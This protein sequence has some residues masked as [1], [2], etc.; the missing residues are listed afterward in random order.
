MQ[1]TS[2]QMTRA[3]S[4]K[5]ICLARFVMMRFYD[6]NTQGLFLMPTCDFL[7]FHHHLSVKNGLSSVSFVQSDEGNN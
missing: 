3:Q 4:E 7:L 1:S 5:N 6:N 2:T